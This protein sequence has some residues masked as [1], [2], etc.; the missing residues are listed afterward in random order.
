MSLRVEIKPELLH[1][2][3][4]RSGVDSLALQ[5]RFGKLDQW[6]AQTV[7]PTFKQ[8][9]AFAK[10]TY[11][12]IG[13]LFLPEPPDERL[14]ILDFRTLANAKITRPGANLLATIYSC[15]QHQ[16]WYREYLLRSL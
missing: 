13:F 10:A 3:I 6:L 5:K 12:P 14:P 8:A 4:E 11:T 2:A 15:Q 1:W 16:Y 9:E 7:K